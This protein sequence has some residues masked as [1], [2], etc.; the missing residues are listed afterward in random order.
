MLHILYSS[1]I[2]ATVTFTYDYIF[3]NEIYIS[4]FEFDQR[5]NWCSLFILYVVAYVI[6]NV[7]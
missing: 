3:D 7:L 6:C 4:L 5:Y 1:E 2:T